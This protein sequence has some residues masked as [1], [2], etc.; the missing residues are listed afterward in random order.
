MRLDKK[1]ARMSG[2]LTGNLA[3]LP[4]RHLPQIQATYH[5]RLEQT[6]ADTTT[7]PAPN[8]LSKWP[9]IPR[10]ITLDEN[11]QRRFVTPADW[12]LFVSAVRLGLDP[13]PLAADHVVSRM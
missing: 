5:D 11:C 12:R 8:N 3:P 2:P 10:G 13:G 9:D 6:G 4:S 7:A 1:K